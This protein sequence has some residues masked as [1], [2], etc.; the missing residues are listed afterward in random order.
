[1]LELPLF[2]LNSV[3]F[4]GT[5]I[6]LH[7][8]EERYKQMVN[9][10]LQ[11]QQPF[12]VVLIAEGREAYGPARPHLIGCT[13]RIIRVQPL[14]QG[15]MDISA[16]GQERFEIQSLR[17]DLPY[18]VGMV[19]LRPL[20][21]DNAE[22]LAKVSGRLRP[23]VSRYLDILS[24]LENVQFSPPDLPADPVALAY[25][26]AAI[27]QQVPQ[28]SKQNL[29]TTEHALE[30]LNTVQ[31]MYQFEVALLNRM[32]ARSEKAANTRSGAPFSDN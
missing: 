28:S 5:L 23:L 9:L 21:R 27:L 19:E 31:A 17:H 26:A 14:A 1:M 4:P 32:A 2:P 20:I 29:L 30:L 11:T 3:L 13:A 6:N 16:I 24:S 18:L 7:I 25:L 12:G 10:C 8:F 22:L 15:R